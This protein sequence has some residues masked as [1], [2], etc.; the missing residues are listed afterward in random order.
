MSDQATQTTLQTIIR[1]EGRSLFQYL[2]DVPPW[3]GLAEENTLARM[4]ECSRAQLEELET[5]GRL[6]QKRYGEMSHM[7]SYPDFTGKNDQALH[8]LLPVVV[9]EQ[10]RL[11]EELER[12]RAGISDAEIG[13]A[14]DRFI[15][16]KRQHIEELESVHTLPHTFRTSTA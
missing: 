14:L 2:R 8:Y 1:R 6:Y 15:V 11:V 13:A 16:L 12:D 9:K 3:I 4:H 5:L 7:G 10:E